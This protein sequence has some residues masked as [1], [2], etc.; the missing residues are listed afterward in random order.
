MITVKIDFKNGNSWVKWNGYSVSMTYR[1]ATS[2]VRD[3]GIADKM[4]C[5]GNFYVL[6]YKVA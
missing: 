4:F 5:E 3:L 6:T 2:L 1:L